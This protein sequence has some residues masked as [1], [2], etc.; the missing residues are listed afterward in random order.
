VPL[1]DLTVLVLAGGLG[2]RLRGVV[3][4]LP[5]V[6]APVAGR[7]FLD[8]L[9]SELA[10]RGAR[11]V[12]LATGYRSDLVRRFAADG[13]RWGL[14]VRYSEE[15]EPLGTGGAVVAARSLLPSDPFVV[16]NGDTFVEVEWEAFA[17]AHRAAGAVITVAVVPV[18]DS[19]RFGRV[20][21][22]D[23]DR[24]AGFTEKGEAGP[25]LVNAGAYLIARDAPAAWGTEA[26]LSLERD[27]LPRYVGRGLQ[28]FRCAGRFLDIGTPVSLEEAQR[29]FV[30]R[31]HDGISRSA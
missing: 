1:S 4:D 11:D 8:H 20:L 7:P 14:A 5:K 2:T 21:L 22:A 18:A 19:A 17:A 28:G 26:P 10:R 29:Y 27:V 31:A 13:A 25:G 3:P 9:L 24:V 15:H 6:L 30:E 12:V 16:L 23:G